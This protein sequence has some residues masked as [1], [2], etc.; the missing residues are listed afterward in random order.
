M[1][2]WTDLSAR[3]VDLLK[4]GIVSGIWIV[5]FALLAVFL[6]NVISALAFKQIL[7]GVMAKGGKD[8]VQLFLEGVSYIAF[9]VLVA[10]SAFLR[11]KK[12]T[13]RGKISPDLFLR[14][15]FVAT[16]ILI[17]PALLGFHPT[18]PAE[19]GVLLFLYMPFLCLGKSIGMTQLSVLLTAFLSAG[20]QYGAYWVG[21]FF[22]R[23][24]TEKE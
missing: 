10:A 18:K 17:I 15:V 14:G 19:N 22:Y 13:K 9:V 23:R 20:I 21:S 16:A 12:R 6:T 24:R 4:T 7:D 5:V 1:K 8:G 2:K 11:G 3:Q